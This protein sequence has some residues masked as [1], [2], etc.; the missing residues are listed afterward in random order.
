MVLLIIVIFG[1]LGLSI[2]WAVD[3]CDAEIFFGGLLCTLLVSVVALIIVGVASVSL[4]EDRLFIEVTRSDCIVPVDTETYI[5]EGTADKKD[6]YFVRIETDKGMKTFSVQIDGTYI[7]YDDNPR[8]EHTECVGFR[9]ARYYLYA[10]PNM[11]RGY[12]TIY[13]PSGSWVVTPNKEGGE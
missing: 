12:W 13:I 11:R 9:R 4:P 8:I 10:I 3:E 1:G 6:Y 7:V 2:W 5:I